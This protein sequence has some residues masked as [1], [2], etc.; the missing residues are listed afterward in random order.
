MKLSINLFAVAASCALA[1]SGLAQDLNDTVAT[2]WIDEIE[3]EAKRV[4]L[5]TPA[6]T[7]ASAVTVLRFDPSIEL[8]TRGLAEGQADVTVQGSLFENIGFKIGALTIVDPQTGH[9]AAGLP[10]DPAFLSAPEVHT[11]I[12]NATGGFNSSIATVAYGIPTIQRG[13]VLLSLIHI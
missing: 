11:G 10:I 8:Q 12:N 9:Y 7:Y 1:T 3:V 6:G 2:Q 5:D 4:A 13:G